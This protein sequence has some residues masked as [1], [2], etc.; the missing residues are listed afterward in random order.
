VTSARELDEARGGDGSAFLRLGLHGEEEGKGNGGGG[1]GG[2]VAYLRRALA[3]LVGPAPAYGLHGVSTRQR[4]PEAGRPLG[5][6]ETAI[7]RAISRLTERFG[8][9]QTPK[10]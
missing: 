3:W 2:V 10:P 4:R 1:T 9:D 5:P 6:A 8:V 7:R